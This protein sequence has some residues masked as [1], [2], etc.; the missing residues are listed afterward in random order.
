MLHK[1]NAGVYSPT[2]FVGPNTSAYDLISTFGATPA[3]TASTDFSNPTPAW[4]PKPPFRAK[5][6]R[7]QP[8]THVYSPTPAFKA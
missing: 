5:R 7:V 6:H 8:N 2:P 3:G 4:G 1:E